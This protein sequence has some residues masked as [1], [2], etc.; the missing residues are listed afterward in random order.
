MKN[1][2]EDEGIGTE[3]ATEIGIANGNFKFTKTKVLKMLINQYIVS[4]LDVNDL[5]VVKNRDDDRNLAKKKGNGPVKRQRQ[6]HYHRLAE[7]IRKSLTAKKM[8]NK[9]KV[10]KL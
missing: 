1:V 8:K 10:H 7:V 6:P 2:N 5:E 4:V 9:D 3:N